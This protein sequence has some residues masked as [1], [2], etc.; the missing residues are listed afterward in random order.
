MKTWATSRSDRCSGGVQGRVGPELP[1]TGTLTVWGCK[2]GSGTVELRNFSGNTLL[3][4]VTI[5]VKNPP[6]TSTPPAVLDL[7]ATASTTSVRL[8][9][10]DLDGASKYRVEHR[11]SAST[12][13]WTPVDTTASAH[14]VT[15][16]APG[17]S[18]AF[19]VRAY[20]DGTKYKAE[21]GAVASTTASTVALVAPP[22]VSNLTSTASSTS[23]RLSWDALDGATKYRVEHRLSAS[24]G[25]WT[26]VETTANAHRVANLT[27]DTSYAF[28]VRAYG[29]GAR[30][31]AAW[32]AEAAATTSTVALAK[33]PPPGGLSASASGANS[34]SVSW[35]ALAGA[36]KYAVQYRQGSSGN[37]STYEDDITGTSATVSGLHCDTGY[38][39]SVRAYGDGVTY[40]AA[41]GA[42]SPASSEVRTSTCPTPT[43]TPTPNPTG[44][45]SASPAKII[46]GQTTTIT[47]TW[48]NVRTTP[49]ISFGPHLAETCPGTPDL[50]AP[51]TE[52]AATATLTLTGC[53]STA[54]ASVQLWDGSNLL[55]S[56]AVTVLPLPEVTKRKSSK[57]RYVQIEFKAHSDYWQ[58]LVI[59]W[60]DIV[61]DDQGNITTAFSPLSTSTPPLGQPLVPRGIINSSSNGAELRGIPHA[62]K[63]YEIRVVGRTEDGA[64]AVGPPYTITR[65]STPDAIG[66]LPDH[67]MMYDLTDLESKSGDLAAWV[68]KDAAGVAARWAAAVTVPDLGLESCKGTA[69][70]RDTACPQNADG[71]VVLVRLGECASQGTPACH[72]AGGDEDEDVS[73][74][75]RLDGVSK[76][77][78]NANLPGS[79]GPTTQAWTAK[80]S[81]PLQVTQTWWSNKSTCGTRGLSCMSS[82]MPSGWPTATGGRHSPHAR[83]HLR[84]NHEPA[85]GRRY[86]QARRQESA[87]SY[88]RDPHQG[89]GM[90]NTMRR[91]W[92]PFWLASAVALALAACGDSQT[93]SPTNLP[94]GPGPAPMATVEQPASIETPA[95]VP[96]ETPAAAVETPALAPPSVPLGDP[97]VIPAALL[98]RES[99]LDLPYGG[100]MSLEV[101]ILYADVIARVTLQSTATSTAQ[102]DYTGAAPDLLAGPARV[103]L[104]GARVPQGLRRQHDKRPRQYEISNRSQG[105]GR[106]CGDARR[107]R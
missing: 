52:Q 14:T 66:H 54:S 65:V 50:N 104:H 80:S 39:F 22:A 12:G 23:V 16:L 42:W 62:N 34:V 73:V 91:A 2:P 35:T 7:T 57:Y 46:K 86:H 90:V 29:D 79:Y 87:H 45:I 72:Q 44:S 5:T 92:L 11:L 71:S 88:L 60:R 47:A 106:R 18:Y 43:P 9:W 95:V 58:R 41:W 36:D 27:P 103:Q 74:E 84:W 15:S 107:T 1:S 37:W 77:I 67:V 78:F 64:V 82:A 69:S 81:R 21:W 17:T 97:P 100:R 56:V 76:I 53:A 40:L 61:R 89:S 8:S 99:G 68:K 63:S 59:E 6:P 85:G 31:R 20:G 33:P 28:K 13:N 48:A 32:G 105:P 55:D 49:N 4:S 25:S 93:A 94:T 3:A 24:T 19:R 101:A 30:Y 98:P 51:D 38:Q 75:F 83:E 102:I 10:D 70:T 26:P 96:T